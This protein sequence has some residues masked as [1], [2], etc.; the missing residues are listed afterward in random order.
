M[1]KK[2]LGIVINKYLITAL[3][4]GIW[5]LY[6]DQNDFISMKERKNEL[7]KINDNIDYLNTE[8]AKMEKENVEVNSN[9]QVLEQYAREHYMLK[10]DNEDVYVIEK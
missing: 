2:V 5:M 8:I 4:F 9:P 1:V 6:F 7:Q 10:R 3:A